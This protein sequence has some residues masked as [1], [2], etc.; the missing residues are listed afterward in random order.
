M[1][2]WTSESSPGKQMVLSVVCAVVGLLFMVVLRGS[3]LSGTNAV[4]GFWLGAL[5]LILGILG[6]LFTGKQT[7][8]VD[9]ATRCITVEDSNR[10]ATK[11]RRIPFD[12]VVGISIGFLGKKSNLVANYYLVLKL[13]D[14]EEYAL[15]APGRFFPGASDR[16]IV[17]GWRDRLSGY[18]HVS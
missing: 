10:L 17:E 4:A 18:I 3:S 1:D 12:S 13:R 6:S 15:F 9:P 8:I 5:L 16:S 14:G 7:V 11:T 2:R